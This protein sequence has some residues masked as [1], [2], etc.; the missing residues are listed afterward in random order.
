M[1]WF[2][3]TGNC[4]IIQLNEELYLKP[5]EVIYSTDDDVDSRSAADLRP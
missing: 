3:F 1:T 2:S 5:E 4:S